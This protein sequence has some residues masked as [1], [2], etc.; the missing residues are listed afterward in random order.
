MIRRAVPLFF[1]VATVSGCQPKAPEA[2]AIPQAQ[3]EAPQLA[4]LT[5]CVNYLEPKLKNV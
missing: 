1:L 5:S 2:P 4:T 3:Q